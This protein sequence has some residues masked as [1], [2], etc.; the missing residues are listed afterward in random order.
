M[1]K[2]KKNARTIHK[3]TEKILDDKLGIRAPS[4]TVGH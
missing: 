1:I 4:S 3:Q 2:K